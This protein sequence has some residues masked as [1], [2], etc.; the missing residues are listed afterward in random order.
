M[1]LSYL[2]NKLS[3]NAIFY[4]ID[5]QNNLSKIRNWHTIIL[6]RQMKESCEIVHNEEN[7]K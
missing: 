7:F 4:F 2:G 6:S 5:R 1:V 3:N